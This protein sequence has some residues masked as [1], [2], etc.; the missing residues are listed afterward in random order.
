MLLNAVFES[1]P[2]HECYRDGKV[3]ETLVG[4][5]Q[6]DEERAESEEGDSQSVQVVV[7]GSQRM[8]E[9]H[10]QGG[11]YLQALVALPNG[12][13]MTKMH[14]VSKPSIVLRHL[15]R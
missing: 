5:G 10:D 8:E 3:E 9:R 12:N 15:P 11:N 13:T 14:D 7:F 1:D 4:D 6:D 2:G